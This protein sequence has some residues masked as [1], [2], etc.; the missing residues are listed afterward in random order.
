[1]TLFQGGGRTAEGWEQRG[2]G[3]R[4]MERRRQQVLYISPPAPAHH[5]HQLQHL[6]PSW[7][8]QR[9]GRTDSLATVS[10][11]IG[12]GAASSRFLARGPMP[13]SAQMPVRQLPIAE[14]MVA[15]NTDLQ[16]PVLLPQGYEPW[17]PPPPIGV[18]LVTSANSST[19]G[20]PLTQDYQPW[21]PLHPLVP[22]MAS[23][24]LNARA[25]AVQVSCRREGGV[26]R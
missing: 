10:S 25:P 21:R 17:H 20:G 5:Q 22:S 12:N 4:G 19:G 24:D 23:M 13:P 3:G 2:R 8:H 6:P 16:V 14:T 18:P 11:W 26:C 1:M 7:R 9:A 15:I